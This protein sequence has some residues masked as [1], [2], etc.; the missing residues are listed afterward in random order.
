MPPR[1]GT[2]CDPGFAVATASRSAFAEMRAFRTSSADVEPTTEPSNETTYARTLC[3]S[4]ACS[5]EPSALDDDSVE[6]SRRLSRELRARRADLFLDR[7]LRA[8]HRE[9]RRDGQ[10]HQS[11]SDQQHGELT[12]QR[13]I[14]VFHLSSRSERRDSCQVRDAL[15]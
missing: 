12:A 2:I 9:C 6:P 14:P 1:N 13:R 11:G 5:S 10:R 4:L 7:T 8:A 3:P 15:S